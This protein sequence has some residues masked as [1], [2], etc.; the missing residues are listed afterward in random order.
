MIIDE[1][2]K[3]MHQTMV[4]RGMWNNDI[5][6]AKAAFVAGLYATAMA[7]VVERAHGQ[8]ISEAAFRIES[9]S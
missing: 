1:T 6:M 5:A 8:E 4:D 3:R 2:W 9:Q 7:T